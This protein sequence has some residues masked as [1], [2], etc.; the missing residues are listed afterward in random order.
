M[1]YTFGGWG[2]IF[3]WSRTGRG[4]S[5]YSWKRETT[6]YRR[7]DSD[8]VTY[9][10]PETRVLGRQ[11]TMGVPKTQLTEFLPEALWTEMIESV[12]SGLSARHRR[13][14]VESGQTRTGDRW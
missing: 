9:F 6:R 5:V 8:R 10:T 7:I 12:V 11:R 4:L 13:S 2:G 1:I 14:K 3:L